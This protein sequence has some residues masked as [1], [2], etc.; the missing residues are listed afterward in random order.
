MDVFPLAAD[1]SNGPINLDPEGNAFYISK[2]FVF[3]AICFA[4]LADSFELDCRSP[5]MAMKKIQPAA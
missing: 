1:C 5:L 4:E 3:L 2:F